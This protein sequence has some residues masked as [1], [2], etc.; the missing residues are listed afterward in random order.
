LYNDQQS[1]RIHG[2]VRSAFGQGRSVSYAEALTGWTLGL[3]LKSVLVHKKWKL[4]ASN[5]GIAVMHM[6]GKGELSPPVIFL[7]SWRVCKCLLTMLLLCVW[8]CKMCGYSGLWWEWDI[9]S[10]TSLQKSSFRRVLFTNSSVELMRWCDMTLQVSKVLRASEARIQ[11][12]Q[13]QARTHVWGN[14]V[15][16]KCSG[17]VNGS[18]LAYVN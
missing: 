18:V 2:Q 11:P 3:L 1:C 5:F 17:V 9:C 13:E 4:S 7:L 15:L 10:G 14:I 8:V 16:Q 12:G 6:T